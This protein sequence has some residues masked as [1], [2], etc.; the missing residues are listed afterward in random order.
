M[1]T[2]A[3][4]AVIVAELTRQMHEGK[5]PIGGYVGDLQTDNTV[6]IDGVFDLHE[7]ATVIQAA[8]DGV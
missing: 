1:T 4:I 3:L 8:K 7:L 2:S 6:L 5:H